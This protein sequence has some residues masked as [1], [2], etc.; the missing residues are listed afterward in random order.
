MLKVLH[1]SANIS[2]LA[3]ITEQMG[4]RFQTRTNLEG[5]KWKVKLAHSF[6]WPRTSWNPLNFSSQYK[7]IINPLGG[8]NL[9]IS[10][11]G[12][13][14]PQVKKLVRE[15]TQC[16]TPSYAGNQPKR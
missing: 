12:W 15:I 7:G 11:A 10:L 3:N 8:C 4:P 13:V 5:H 14:G 6:C 2:E 9:I 16:L 1:R